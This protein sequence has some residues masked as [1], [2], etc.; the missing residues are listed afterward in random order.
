MRGGRGDE[1]GR[2]DEG[3]RGGEGGRS[4]TRGGKTRLEEVREDIYGIQVSSIA[5]GEVLTSD[6]S[7]FSRTQPY[8]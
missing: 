8:K 1:G 3:G 6:D 7:F 2:R 4:G 5:T